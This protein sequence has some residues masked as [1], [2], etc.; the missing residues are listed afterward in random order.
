VLFQTGRFFRS[1]K[2]L[3]NK[4]VGLVLNPIYYFN[5]WLDRKKPGYSTL[6]FATEWYRINISLG[7]L[8]SNLSSNG[9]ITRSFY[10]GI[11][12]EIMGIPGFGVPGK[13]NRWLSDTMNSR[14]YLDLIVD[15]NGIKEYSFGTKVVLFGRAVQNLVTERE[16][17]LGYSWF[18]GVGSSFEIFKKRA[19]S[20]YDSCAEFYYAEEYQEVPLPTG[21]TDK[22]SSVGLVGPVFDFCG[23]SRDLF[24]RLTLEAYLDFALINALAL[25]RYTRNHDLRGAKATLVNYGYYYALGL[26]TQSR[27]EL[28]Y[29]QVAV[30]ASLDYR[31]YDSLEGID[32]F[33]EDVTDDFNIRDTRLRTKLSVGYRLGGSPLALSIS[34]ERRSSSGRIKEVSH[35][36]EDNRVYMQL[37]L[38]L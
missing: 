13:F 29:R 17:F 35:H 22:Y 9:N 38:N 3:I 31:L 15:S 4:I 11:R 18:W 1:R 5:Q 10:F 25:N 20:Y 24:I 32:R 21:F 36:E 8:Q 27:L 14:L 30:T 37:R 23:Y 7:Q 16:K 19:T 26:N 12:N 33:Q 34:F 2:G 28:S 6:N